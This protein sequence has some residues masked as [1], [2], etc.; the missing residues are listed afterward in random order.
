MRGGHTAHLMFKI[1]IDTLGEGS[2]CA[3]SKNSQRAELLRAAKAIIWDEIGA[4]HR[5]AVEAV[6]RTMQDACGNNRPFGG[7]I[8]LLAG[9]FKQ[10]L[11][12]IPKGS[13]EDIINATIQRSYLWDNI[14]ILTL[15]ENMRLQQGNAD[16]HEF[17]QWLLDIGHGRN[18]VENGNDIELLPGMRVDD[19][20]TLLDTIYP[21]INTSPPPPPEYFMN[22][23]ILAP[24]SV[25]K[26][27]PVRFGAWTETET[28]LYKS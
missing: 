25:L 7:K 5:H 12:V 15:T 3:V 2:V 8:V 19:E 18:M 16:A 10:T 13:K 20:D 14:E 9:D 23:M 26:S 6:D 1:P 22:R 11:P 17:A 28:G 21:A 4:Q 24:S 27:G